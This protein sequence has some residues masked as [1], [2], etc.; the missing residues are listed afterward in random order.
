MMKLRKRL[1]APLLSAPM[2]SASLSASALL[3]CAFAALSSCST[4][5][6]APLETQRLSKAPRITIDAARGVASTEISVM[7]YNVAGLPW[8][9]RR[10]RP[11]ALKEIARDMLALHAAERAP[12]VLVLQEAFTPISAHVGA[13]YAH[14]LRGPAAADHADIDA[15]P[16]DEGFV[17]ARRFEKGERLGKLLSSG[18]YVFSDYPVT[19][20]HMT[21]FQPTSCAGYDCLAN[22]GAMIAVID[23]PGAP[24][25]IQILTT[26]LNANGASGVSP[27]RALAA[28]RQQVDEMGALMAKGLNPNWPVIYAGDFNT[29]HS[30]ARFAHH[31]KTMPGMLVTNYCLQP[32]SGCD[33]R[34]PW[35][36]DAPWLDTQDLQGFAS[37]PRI[38]VRPVRAEKMFDKPRDGRML[39]DHDAYVVTYRFSW[40]LENL[41][42]L[43][44]AA[45][46]ALG[47]AF[48]GD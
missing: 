20:S 21:P 26:H 6:D 30:Q 48:A 41:A 45:G 8:P 43:D 15:P 47:A 10:G 34:M 42:A 12:D 44:G 3:L 40:K 11:E 23:I 22:K 25:P 24:A 35:Q 18:L 17:R 5:F 39:S 16:I 46:A 27:S 1:R 31:A 9:I 33:A 19:A 36:G 37:A 14:R 4:K 13:P 32:Q 7:T 28:H 38:D 29:R 2:L